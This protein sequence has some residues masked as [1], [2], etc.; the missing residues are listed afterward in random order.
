MR[1][2]HLFE[3]ETAYTEAREER[4]I[5]PWVSL[6]EETKKVNYNISEEERKEKL[7][8]MPLTF[9]NVGD[10]FPSII[11]AFDDPE[12]DKNLSFSYNDGAWEGMPAGEPS[13]F[14]LSPGDFVRFKGTNTSLFGVHIENPDES[15][16]FKV[17]GNIMS[18]LYGDNFSDKTEIT[19][20]YA[21]G[22]LF[23]SCH[24]LVSAEDLM[25]PATALASSCYYAMFAGCISLTTAPELPA[26]ALASSCYSFMFS[27]CTSLNYIKCL[28]T[29]ISARNCTSN[30]VNGVAATGTFIKATSTDW[31]VKTGND[32]IPA[33]WTV[34]VTN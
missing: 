10:D 25:L 26:T 22:E 3:T 32:G 1:F 6:T 12:A 16:Q 15:A 30:W 19:E 24:N 33:G 21:F 2:L 9:E 7:L 14:T 5:E 13:T 34:Q 17:S 29:N 23:S 28:A 4:Y 8:N 18:L 11:W 27:G 20:D 31:S